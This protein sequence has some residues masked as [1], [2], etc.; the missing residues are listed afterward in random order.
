MK[1]PAYPGTPSTADGSGAI[2]YVETAISEAATAYPITPTTNMGAGFQEKVSNGAK[3]LWG[4]PLAFV[5]L[6]SEHSAATACEGFALA[7][8]RVANFTS[9]QGLILMKEVLYTISGKRLPVVFNI[10]A[11]ALTS[12]SLNVHGG[13]DDIFGVMDVGWGCLFGRNVQESLDLALIARRAAEATLTPFFNVQ[14][15]F[16]TTHTVESVRLPELELMKQFVGDPR[17]KLR[18]LFDPA[19]GMMIGVVQNQ[20]SY[21]K[22]KVAQRLFYDKV[23]A[24]VVESM[25]LYRDLTG[26]DYKLVDSYRMEDAEY[27]LVGLGTAMETAKLAVDYAR[28][29]LGWKV[30]LV[31]PT[32]VRPFPAAEIVQALR[33]CKGFSVIERLDEPLA[34]NNPLT[35]E[36]KAA[37]ADSLQQKQGK[38]PHLMLMPEIYSGV[39]GMGGRDFRVEDSLA[40][41]R[42]MIEGNREKPFF[43][44]GVSGDWALGPEEPVAPSTKGAFA[45]RGHSV[46][47]YGSVTT[48]KIIATLCSELFGLYVQAFPKYGSE[49]KGLPTT[50]YLTVAEEPIL[51]HC[52]LNNVDF[53]PVLDS[54]AF[55]TGNPLAGLSQGGTLFLQSPLTDPKKV[56]ET[57]PAAAQ[58]AIAIKGIKVLYMDMVA[59]GVEFA[60]TADLQQRMQGILLLGVYLKTA[61]FAKGMEQPKLF[62]KLRGVLGK[63]FGRRGDDVVEAN[64]KAAQRGFESV[65]EVPAAIIQGALAPT[66]GQS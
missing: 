7:G 45:M 13:H 61:P 44:C 15:G 40:V 11:R 33:A 6:E 29:K 46:G 32:C 64:L 8:G 63:Y 42:N 59:A 54:Y 50:F 48:N 66:G 39:Y 49:K 14:D 3:N 53:V 27:A 62:E 58:R 9:G 51:S 24:A 65:H 10:G 5:E 35:R 16:L 12:H 25:E 2:V 4:T 37:F 52:E 17:Q 38:V 20:E 60:P 57:L 47:G 55:R 21:M 43:A 22:G 34:E 23:R 18:D 56:W 36:I 28:K 30:G 41:F 19:K 26:R 31:H 1:Q